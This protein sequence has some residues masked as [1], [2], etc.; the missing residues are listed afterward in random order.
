MKERN[1]M[2][3]QIRRAITLILS[4][5]TVVGIASCG[6]EQTPSDDSKTPVGTTADVTSLKSGP[7]FPDL[8]FDN[9]EILFLT[10]DSDNS[11]YMSREIYAE[12]QNGE[13]INDAVY[14][15]NLKVEEQFKVKIAEERVSD[16]TNQAHRTLLAGDDVYDV[17]MPYMNTSI[18]N[19]LEGL[20][21]NL[22]DVPH[23]E[24]DNPWWDQRA[25]ESLT[26]DGNL[27][28][29]TGDISILDNE[30][31]MVIFFNKKIIEDN[32]LDNPYE[33]VRSG[34]WTMDKFFGMIGDAAS[35]LNGD[36]EMKIEDDQF[37]LFCQSNVPH[38]LWFGAGERISTVDKSGNIKLSMKSERSA[39][40][41]PYILENCYSDSVSQLYSWSDD[42]F[43]K[44][45]SAFNGGR[46]LFAGWALVDINSIRDCKFDFGI[47]PYPKYNESQDEYYNL[48]STVLV[49]GVSIPV[50]NSEPEK[51]GLILEAMAY[52]SVDTL[53]AAYYDNALHTRYIRDEESGEM[54]DIIFATRV[55]DLGFISNVGGLGKLMENM[56]SKKKTNFASEYESMSSAAETALEKLTE[57]FRKAAVSQK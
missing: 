44:S 55:Y 50:T 13:L 35:D 51:A 24:L 1:T 2:N 5:A 3:K 20:Y 46:I 37:G 27:Y 53:T 8:E 31:S 26:V 14:K 30:C 6:K 40:M 28:F 49:P 54:L 38:S 32:K 12:S 36:S 41:I 15:R 4:A 21:L 43:R 11:L 45:V 52:Y 7:V 57:S 47:L 48:I 34:K 25:N 17:V 56:F 10:E 22:Y 18:N 33:L 23:L 42:G 9:E 29:T 16:A 19:A 39:E